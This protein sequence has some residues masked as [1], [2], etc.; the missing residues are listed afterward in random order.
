[1]KPTLTK[2]ILIL[3]FISCYFPMPYTYYEFMRVVSMVGFGYLAY[4]SYKN[5]NDIYW[6]YGLSAL[7]INPFY[8]F[9]ISKPIWFI[10]DAIWIIFLI[11]TIYK[12][13]KK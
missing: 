2:T 7:L 13:K 4:N 6:F 3:L 1:M 12:K 8:K 10:I 9:Y 5:Q 11:W